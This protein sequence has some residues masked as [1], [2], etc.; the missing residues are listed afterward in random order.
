SGNQP[1][2]IPNNAEIVT[3]II[4][5]RFVEARQLVADLTSFVSPE[6][7]VVANQEGNSIVITDTQA[8]IR[9]LLEIIR[10][11]DDSAEAE[12][13]IQVFPLK[14]A[15]PQD[16]A[17]ELASIF[18][19]SNGG[20]QAPTSVAGRGGRGGARGGGRGGGGPGRRHPSQ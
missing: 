1:D 15:N 8:N 18:P 19:N 11:I 14:Y 9:H 2:Q 13:K 4:P 10:A 5:I 17:S 6:A 7:T 16:V 20:T 3:Q 12:T